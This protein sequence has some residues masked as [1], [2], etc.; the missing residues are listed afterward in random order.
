MRAAPQRPKVHTKLM[1]ALPDVVA[2]R[3]FSSHVG[4]RVSSPGTGGWLRV[5]LAPQEPA[6]GPA[7][8]VDLA[9]GQTL[10][11]PVHFELP[12]E[13]RLPSTEREACVQFKVRATCVPAEA[14][15]GTSA[16]TV[17]LRCRHA[18][19]SFA[20]TFVDHDGSIAAA[21]A[22]MPHEPC[23][24][25]A[26]CPVLLSLSGVGVAPG[27]Q[28]DAHK[29]M[30]AGARDYV[31][32][33]AS[34]WVLCPER[35]GAHNWEGPGYWTARAAVRAL[36]GLAAAFD[37]TRALDPLRLLY[38]GHS[39]GGHGALMQAINKRLTG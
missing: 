31:F 19:Q 30:P 39:R 38:A 17:Q 7:V 33:F 15:S 37:A 10:G 18:R 11:V 2:R 4:V 22:I 6:H 25:P 20:F 28:A 8:Q 26:G 36:A 21:A 35:A 5:M 12:A 23:A 16:V 32:G 13:L 27:Q 3:Q 1:A 14:C 24:Q 34:A 9:P 29:F